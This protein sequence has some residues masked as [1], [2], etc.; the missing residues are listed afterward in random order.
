M[1]PQGL[2]HAP[3]KARQ[4]GADGLPPGP[5]GSAGPG[6][7]VVHIVQD[8]PREAVYRRLAALPLQKGHHVPVA[9]GAVF[10][11]QLPHKAHPLFRPADAGDSGKLSS[12]AGEILLH[13]SQG[14]PPAGF[15]V[16]GQP[17]G[18]GRPAGI[19]APLL[20]LIGPGLVSEQHEKVPIIQGKQGPPDHI[21]PDGE[22]LLPL[23]PLHVQGEDRHLGIPRRRKS[24]ADETGEVGPPA[25][26]P[27]RGH[28]QGGVVQVI[29]PRGQ[30]L[31]ILPQAEG[32]G[33]A[34]VVVAIPQALVRD[35]LGIIQDHRPV[36]LRVKGVLQQ[37]EVVVH[38][39]GDEQDGLS[40]LSGFLD[41]VHR[42]PPFLPGFSRQYDTT[43]MG[44]AQGEG[45]GSRRPGILQV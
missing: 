25:G 29:F 13:P 21:R 5:S 7:L 14:K 12:H 31:E 35:P 1:G 16:L 18:P 10:G 15:Q 3:L 44:L 9:Q 11:I 36:L 6:D 2:C 8:V 34:H 37:G 27:R 41:L 17:L 24:L 30:G 33:V 45:G 28:Q 19:G 4:K 32:E 20:P 23:Q 42:R 22:G 39:G 40:R 38:H 26:V 43:W